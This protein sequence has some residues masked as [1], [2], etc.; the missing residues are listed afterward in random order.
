MTSLRA[1]DLDAW[2]FL[3]ELIRVSKTTQG[4]TGQHVAPMA[5]PSAHLMGELKARGREMYRLYYGEPDQHDDL[6]VGLAVK[7]K[8]TFSN[9]RA[10][11]QAQD[12]DIRIS[13]DIFVTWLNTEGMTS[14]A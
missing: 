1:D 10:T 4:L 11:T 7:M 3:V 13:R 9:P 5:V 8:R 2:A 14:G 6:V 12:R